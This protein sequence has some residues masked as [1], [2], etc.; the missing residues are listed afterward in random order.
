MPVTRLKGRMRPRAHSVFLYVIAL[1]VAVAV[2]A[3][4]MTGKANAATVAGP[5]L[6]GMATS[7]VRLANLA[8]FARIGQS[9]LTE[10]API[11]A[12]PLTPGLIINLGSSYGVTLEDRAGGVAITGAAADGSVTV[13]KANR[14]GLGFGIVTDRHALL[15]YEYKAILAPGTTIKPTRDGGFS[16]VNAAGAVIGHVSPAYAIDSTGKRLPASY[17]FDSATDELIV[18]TDATHAKGAVFIDPSWKCWATASAFGALWILAAAAWVFSDGTA[19]W[20]AWA[21]RA[22]FGLSLNAANTTA[23]ACALH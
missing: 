9:Q 19:A 8:G 22:W 17:S 2:A 14:S 7:A 1:G 16:Q 21:L 10:G 12:L 3:A 15:K 20:A 6:S 13:V 23:K 18:N 4:G 5:K 11:T